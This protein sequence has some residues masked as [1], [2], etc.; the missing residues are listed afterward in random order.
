VLAISTDDRSHAK[1]VWQQVLARHFRVLS[2]PGAAVIRTYGM[3]H[4]HGGRG[5]DI[6]LDTSLFIDKEG[7]ERWRK[8]SQTLP[9]LPTADEVLK[10]IR[11]GAVAQQK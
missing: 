9:D 3:L 2:D 4:P 11:Q 1:Q 6:A 10:S 8:V 5:E 7:I